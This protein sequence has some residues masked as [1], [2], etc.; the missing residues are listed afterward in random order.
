[1]SASFVAR[2][3]ATMAATPQH[4]YQ[5]LTKQPGRLGSLLGEE[6]FRSEVAHHLHLLALSCAPAGRPDPVFLERAS[7][8]WA[9][10][11]LPNVWV[12]TS[13]ELDRYAWRAD[14][15][16][17]AMARIR[18]LSLEPLL[19]PLRASI[20]AG[21]LGHRG[22]GKRLG[23]SAA[24]L[25]WV[26]DLRDRCVE[27]GIAFFFKLLCPREF[28]GQLAR[29]S[30]WEVRGW[31]GSDPPSLLVGVGDPLAAGMGE[32]A[33]RL[34]GID[35]LQDQHRGGQ[36]RGA[37]DAKSAVG[38]DM[39]ASVELS[40]ELAKPRQ[41][42][43]EVGDRPVGDGDGDELKAGVLRGGGFACQADLESFGFGECADEHVDADAA[44]GAQ[45][46]VEPVAAAWLGHGAE[47]AGAVAVDGVKGGA[48]PQPPS[49]GQDGTRLG[50]ISRG[51][52]VPVRRRGEPSGP[53]ALTHPVW[54]RPRL[55]ARSAVPVH[56]GWR[57]SRQR[58][59]DFAILRQRR[60]VRR[61]A[62]LAAIEAVLCA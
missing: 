51:R 3:L 41:D 20:L 38:D 4:T 42:G 37:A 56:G 44:Q 48:Q 33:P 2:V 14:L 54:D 22:W 28:V 45:F 57:G 23:A 26:R 62:T 8:P 15:L 12:G 50:G 31:Q 5:V 53:G 46:V 6:D 9:P 49:A 43:G 30:G 21:R 10:W 18:F 60:R 34:V 36:Q 52:S 61:S 1:V 55:V 47:P 27:L 7:D 13:I 58:V 59:R 17:Q 16:R 29:P 11:P 19:G 32:S 25:D 35:A 40:N 39:P 24:G